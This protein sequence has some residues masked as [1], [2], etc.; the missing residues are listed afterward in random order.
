VVSRGL[1]PPSGCGHESNHKRIGKLPA[2]RGSDQQSSDKPDRRTAPRAAQA[3]TTD[4]TQ[5]ERPALPTC[6]DSAG[7]FE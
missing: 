6:A 4:P 7:R 3:T 5:C 2:A 1:R